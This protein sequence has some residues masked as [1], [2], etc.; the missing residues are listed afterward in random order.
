MPPR[1]HW[2]S[3]N[4]RESPSRCFSSSGWSTVDPIAAAPL[5][6]PAGATFRPPFPLAP[7]AAGG[8]M[9]RGALPAWR[10]VWVK[11]G[12]FRAVIGSA[13]SAP[14]AG[15]R[16]AAARLSARIEL[17]RR[18]LRGDDIR[19]ALRLLLWRLARIG[20]LDALGRPGS[21]LDDVTGAGSRVRG[22]R[23]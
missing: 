21:T 13:M 10:N 23:R 5:A 18:S 7:T 14:D 3:A 16:A 22:R 4:F 2:S 20:G 17:L 1:S 9:L 6:L 15:R 8:T 12:F 11:P 19:A